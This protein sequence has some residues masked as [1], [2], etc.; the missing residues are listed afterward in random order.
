MRNG[1]TRL[2]QIRMLWVIYITC[3]DAVQD[4]NAM[5]ADEGTTVRGGRWHEEGCSWRAAAGSNLV[6]WSNS[7]EVKWSKRRRRGYGALNAKFGMRN[8]HTEP[9]AEGRRGSGETA[10]RA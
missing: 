9:S 2:Q 5:G 7:R 10:S 3:R 4:A 6:D 1:R 8:D